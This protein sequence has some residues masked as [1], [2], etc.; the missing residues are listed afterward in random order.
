[1][2]SC[3]VNWE[4]ERECFRDFSR[5]CAHFYS[6]RKE[7]TLDTDTQPQVTLVPSNTTKRV[8]LYEEGHRKNVS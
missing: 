2:L 7:Y 6:V 3:Q 8:G 4:N 5:E 1:M